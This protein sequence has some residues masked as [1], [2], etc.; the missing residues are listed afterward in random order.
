MNRRV[1]KRVSFSEILQAMEQRV[2]GT[3][4]LVS[5]IGRPPV[6]RHP[7]ARL[8]LL[9]KS[10]HTVRVHSRNGAARGSQA[11]TK[12]RARRAHGKLSQRLSSFL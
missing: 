4:Y 12:V 11:L 1:R 6:G 10:V 3:A 9:D 5:G 7:E 2:H 8:Q